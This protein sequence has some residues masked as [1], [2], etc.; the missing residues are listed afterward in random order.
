MDQDLTGNSGLTVEFQS[1]S[2]FKVLKDEM[3][4]MNGTWKLQ[5]NTDGLQIITLPIVNELT[6]K[7]NMCDNKFVCNDIGRDICANFFRRQ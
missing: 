5:A 6:G 7:F 3:P 1:D 4:Y 2:T